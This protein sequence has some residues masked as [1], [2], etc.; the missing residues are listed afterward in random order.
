MTDQQSTQSRQHIRPEGQ[1]HGP[2]QDT[3]RGL[4]R[5]QEDSRRKHF[6]ETDQ[7]WGETRYQEHTEE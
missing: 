3:G 7:R 1:N 6:D 4:T 5:D 2:G